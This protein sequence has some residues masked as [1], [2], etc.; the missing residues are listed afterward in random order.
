[1]KQPYR[2]PVQKLNLVLKYFR[3]YP[4]KNCSVLD[5]GGISGYRSL[6]EQIF[7]SADVYILNLDEN[8]KSTP[9]IRASALELPFVDEAWDVVTAFDIIEHLTLPDTFLSECHRVLKHNGFFIISSPNLATFYNRIII[10]LGFMPF[11]YD[12]SR[13]NVGRI[14]KHCIDGGPRNQLHMGHVSVFTYDGL[15]A[16]LHVHGFRVVY[17]DGFSYTDPFYVELDPTKNREVKTYKLRRALNAIMPRSAREGI[18]II[19]K[20]RSVSAGQDI[21]E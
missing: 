5:I 7:R 15:R 3:N 9:S 16:L 1:M 12:P 14:N 8:V 11:H 20:K 2:V 21:R 10:P 13:Y 6:L 4:L 17:S 18:L 19:A